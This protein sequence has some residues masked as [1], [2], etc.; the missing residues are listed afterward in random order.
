MVKLQ[1]GLL[2]VAVV[3]LTLASAH[4]QN[5]EA[6]PSP[7]FDCPYVNY[8]DSDCPQLRKLWEEQKRRR[9]QQQEAPSAVPPAQQSGAETPP[10]GDEDENPTSEFDAGETYLLFPKESLAPDAP[11]LFRLLLA[12]PTLDNARRY[13]RWYARRTA[14]LQAVQA[15]IRLAGSELQSE[16]K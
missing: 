13:V 3:L 8:F 11:P 4:G 9:L 10:Q 7:Y 12:E 1:V 16:M 15:L 2:S 5:L 14:R 6:A